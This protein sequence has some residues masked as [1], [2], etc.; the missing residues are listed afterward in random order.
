MSHATLLIGILSACDP[1]RGQQPVELSRVV[2]P[3]SL[4]D[5]MLTRDSG[6]ATTG[7]VYRVYLMPHGQATPAK[8]TER[9]RAD[10]V[11]GLV[12]QWAA[13]IMLI[14]EFTKARVFHFSNFWNSREVLD[15]RHTVELRLAPPSGSAL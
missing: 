1:I 5:A 8:G 7:F 10:H 13:P 14:V 12:L 3:D 2:S 4:V 11:E 9:L 6:G 15:F